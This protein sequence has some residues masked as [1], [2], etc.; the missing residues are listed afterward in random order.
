[1][2]GEGFEDLVGAFLDLLARV[3]VR[4]EHD[5]GA[6]RCES[7]ADHGLNFVR[8]RGEYFVAGV[9]RADVGRLELE[10]RQ[11]RR[12]EGR[13]RR[14]TL[15]FDASIFAAVGRG[16]RRRH[17]NAVLRQ[18]MCLASAASERLVRAASLRSLEGL[19]MR[20]W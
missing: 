10:L 6:A 20:H 11:A 12:E 5:V 3:G 18:N 1:M 7:V 15:P 2:V 9:F 13:A 14:A 8:L 4:A 17:M 19:D 16:D